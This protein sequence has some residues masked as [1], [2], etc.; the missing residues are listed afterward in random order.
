MKKKLIA[1]LSFVFALALACGILAACAKEQSGEIDEYTYNYHGVFEDEHDASVTIDGRLEDSIW[2]NKNY[3][4]NTA[5]VTNLSNDVHIGVTAAMT[6]RGVYVGAYATDNNVQYISSFNEKNTNFRFYVTL[7][8]VNEYNA[9]IVKNF[10]VD[11][12]TTKSTNGARVSCEAVYDEDADRFTVELFVSWKA[13]GVDTAAYDDGIPDQIKLYTVY[14][15]VEDSSGNSYHDIYS[16]FGGTNEPSMYP[17]FD[18]SGYTLVDKEGAVMGD[19]YNGY[20]KTNA[21]DLSKEA[22]GEVAVAGAN[23]QIIFFKEAYSSSFV[24]ETYV[25]YRSGTYDSASK[26]GLLALIDPVNFRAMLLNTATSN[27]TKNDDGYSVNSAGI[28]GLTYYPSATWDLKSLGT[29]GTVDMAKYGNKVKLKMVKD[30][31]R[32]YYFVNDVFVCAEVCQYIEGEAFAGFYALGSDAVFSDYRY[33]DLE[34]DAD[35]LAAELEGAVRIQTSYGVGGSLSADAIAVKSGGS[36]SLTFENW[37]GYALN[38]VKVNGEEMISSLAETASDGVLTLEEVTQ[39]VTVEAAFGELTG[40]ETV[41]M[42]LKGVNGEAISGSAVIENDA[43]ELYRW[44]INAPASASG[45]S[46]PLPAGDYTATIDSP[47]L[48]RLVYEFSVTAGGENVFAPQLELAMIGSVENEDFSVASSQKGWDYSEEYL[49]AMNADQN[50]NWEFVYFTEHYSDTVIIKMTVQN[51]TPSGVE[52]EKYPAALWT[53]YDGTNRISLGVINRKVRVFHTT[54]MWDSSA[55]GGY[56]QTATDVLSKSL[57]DLN[58]SL[59]L[60]LIRYQNVYYIFEEVGGSHVLV[61]Q[62]EEMTKIPG[63]AIYGLTVNSATNVALGLRF[64]DMYINSGTDA[65]AEIEE[66]LSDPGS[67]AFE[68][69]IFGTAE[70]AD[71][72]AET[73]PGDYDFSE[74]AD[75]VVTATAASNTKRAWFKDVYSDTVLI[76]MKVTNNAPEGRDPYSAIG[77]SLYDGSNYTDILSINGKVRVFP[78]GGTTGHRTTVDPVMSNVGQV[79]ATV[80]MMYIRYQGEHYIFEKTGG[81]YVLCWSSDSDYGIAMSDTYTISVTGDTVYG[82]RFDTGG[83]AEDVELSNF[84]IVSGDD[85]VSEIESYLPDA[86]EPETGMFGSVTVNDVQL[87]MDNA[88]FTE[89]DGVLTGTDGTVSSAA[90]L[91]NVVSDT[92]M[93]KTTIHSLYQEGNDKY[94]QAGF[95]VNDGTNK[96]AIMLIS[97]KVYVYPNGVWISD[98]IKT[99]QSVLTGTLLGADATDIEIMFIRYEGV[100]YLFEKVDGEYNMVWSM[101]AD[102]SQIAQITGEAAYGFATHFSSAGGGFTFSGT[103]VSYGENAVSEIEGYLQNIG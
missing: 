57:G 2:Q 39:D 72:I 11:L 68:G 33:K 32:M 75:G 96:I 62:S 48:R 15:V 18:A 90:Y 47:G 61:Y 53:V 65:V 103:S 93:I 86:P 40:A 76:R 73:M 36:F 29:D 55:N 26:I 70:G 69:T 1:I 95:V 78:Y 3:F 25:E 28:Y 85:A 6:E 31:A 17:I 54:G 74:E 79:N 41:T 30:G 22:E 80:E 101:Q 98:S 92:V 91:R 12:R 7:P 81:T 43:N 102:D 46:F 50:A 63:K 34:G 24:T 14:R 5:A 97:Q 10:R 38:S 51:T 49:G 52:R 45:Y 59:D 89:T 100:Y 8:E 35:G 21:W 44:A 87:T 16:G 37:T 64:S 82:I 42:Q 99:P 71:F 4:T 56:T 66:Y 77:F 27:V 83:S 20:A 60:V 9:A 67:S 19:A 23:W 84:Y 58:A 13:L 94:G 88:V